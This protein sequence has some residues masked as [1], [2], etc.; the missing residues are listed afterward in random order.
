MVFIGFMMFSIFAFFSMPTGFDSTDVDADRIQGVKSLASVTTLKRRLQLA[1]TG[2][3]IIMTI[4]PFTYIN[5]GYNMLLPITVML[6]GLIF[7][8]NLVPIMLSLSPAVSTIE[9][10]VIMKSRKTIVTFIFV[11]SICL[12]IGS[13]NLSGFF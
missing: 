11:L 10:G 7:L 6:G 9:M 4:T 5:F 2:M 13:I 3:F 8:R 1:I 12:V